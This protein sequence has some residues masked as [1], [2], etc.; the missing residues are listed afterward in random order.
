MWIEYKYVWNVWKW[1]IPVVARSKA[2]ECGPSFA[3]VVGSNHTAGI[4]VC[5]L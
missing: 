4:D 1:P 5:L 3:E 2:Y